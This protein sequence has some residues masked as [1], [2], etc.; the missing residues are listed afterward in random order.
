[1]LFLVLRLTKRGILLFLLLSFLGLVLL[2]YLLYRRMW[3]RLQ[4]IIEESRRAEAKEGK[5]E[6]KVEEGKEADV[7]RP[8]PASVEKPKAMEEK[9]DKE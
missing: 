8:S 3:A 2:T 1:M 7:G 5:E 6:K 4:G 9:A